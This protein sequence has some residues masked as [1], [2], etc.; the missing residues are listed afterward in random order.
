MN[1][2]REGKS[3]RVRNG[4]SGPIFVSRGRNRDLQTKETKDDLLSPTLGT[5]FSHLFSV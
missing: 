1:S 4:L 3:L 5:I 2:M